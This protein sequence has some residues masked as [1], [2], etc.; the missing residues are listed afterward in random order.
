VTGLADGTGQ[1][2]HGPPFTDF[3]REIIARGA[4]GELPGRPV[5]SEQLAERFRVSGDP[6][7]VAYVF[8]GAGRGDTMR[9]NEA[10]F[11]RWQIV[12]RVLRDVGVRDLA[13]R[14]LGTDLPAPLAIAPVGA[15]GMFHPEGELATA[16]AAAALGLP[17]AVST[18]ASATLEAIAGAAP[19][20]KWFQVYWPTERELLESFLQRAETSGYEAIVLTVDAGVVAWRPHDLQHGFQ[21]GLRGQGLANY[22]SDPVFRASLPRSPEDDPAGAAAAFGRVFSNPRLTWDDIAFLRAATTLP[23]AIKGI[24][25]PDDARRAREHGVD[26]IVVSNHGGRQIDG[27]IGSL[28]ALP[29]IVD[30]VGDDLDVLLDSGI[31]GGA[32][33]LKA[34]ALGARAVL[35]GRPFVWGL[36]VGGEAGVLEVLRGLTAE[37]ESALALSGA[38]TPGELSPSLLR[39]AAS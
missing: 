21:P 30:A 20:P 9:A 25:H 16:R 26:A 14:V 34:L 28:D 24:L 22:L 36:G 6:R 8:G 11:G 12:P 35:V 27:E 31:R 29:A 10:A 32:D 4:A 39:R 15:Q 19:G 38:R 37:L 1:A 5:V 13:V 3:Q 18:M 23:I 33:I 2:L 7:M 17:M